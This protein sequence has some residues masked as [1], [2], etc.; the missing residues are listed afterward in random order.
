MTICIAAICDS[1]KTLVLAS[2]SMLTSPMIEFEQPTKKMTEL[3]SH[4]IAMTAGNALA[5]T[6]LFNSVRCSIEVL[7]SPPISKIV[8]KIKE[9]YQLIRKREICEIILKPKGFN[10]FEEFWQAQRIM[11]PDISMKIQFQIDNYDYGLS[12]ITAGI[13]NN[14]AQ[15]HNIEDPGTSQCYDSIGFHTI[16]SGSPHAINTLTARVCHQNLPLEEVFMIVYEAKKMAERAPG[17]GLK[18]NFTIIND[19]KITNISEEAVDKLPPI[20]EKW[21]RK[22]EAW[23]KELKSTII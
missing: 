18:S 19:K 13:S 11:L 1:Y 15:I 4:C 12:I 21:L 2:D 5:H 8:E 3:G 7:K 6:E 17:V 22:D 14:L 23:K 10:G 16:G 20:Y 9:C